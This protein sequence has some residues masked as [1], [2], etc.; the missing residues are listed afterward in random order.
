MHFLFSFVCDKSR[1]V[2][3]CGGCVSTLIY[4]DQVFLFFHCVNFTHLPS[5]ISC[6]IDFNY[7]N[8]N[9]LSK[10]RGFKSAGS[11][12]PSF[13]QFATTSGVRCH[14]DQPAVGTGH[15][16]DVTP[17]NTNG[18]GLNFL[19]LVQKH[20]LN[21]QVIRQQRREIAHVARWL[22]LYAILFKSRRNRQV[23]CEESDGSP[24]T[25]SWENSTH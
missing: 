11:R 14:H 20:G 23:V 22:L 8:A 24:D 19:N 18:I 13:M 15:I 16:T 12:Y 6:F 9:C 25:R 1:H 2:C 21:L 17:A 3:S 5:C 7:Y 4:T 10:L